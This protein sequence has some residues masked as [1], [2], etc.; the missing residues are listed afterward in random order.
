M[1]EQPDKINGQCRC[2][3]EGNLTCLWNGQ[4][5]VVYLPRMATYFLVPEGYCPYCGYSLAS[6]GFAYRMVRAE[7]AAALEAELA[8]YKQALNI[9]AHNT[10]FLSV[11]GRSVEFYEQT[12]LDLARAEA[13]GS[14]DEPEASE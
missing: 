3:G 10:A 1:S 2:I 4:E 14:E 5:W 11:S 7:D 8:L 9:E 12:A 6:D 13:E